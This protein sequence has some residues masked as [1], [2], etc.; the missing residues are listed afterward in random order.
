MQKPI[1]VALI[2]GGCVAPQLPSQASTSGGNQ[3]SQDAHTTRSDA[4]RQLRGEEI[5][6]LVLNK[7][8]VT[9]Q[10]TAKIRTFPREEYYLPD[11]QLRVREDRASS[12]IAY[13]LEG[14]CLCISAA[15]PIVKL[16]SRLFVDQRGNY[17]R[18]DIKPNSTG[19]VSIIISEM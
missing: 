4:L 13:W 6:K 7:R 2:L 15:S 1:F 16:C 19:P 8:I 12:R 17:Y 5:L 3:P 9:D 11:G 14:D 10:S 18:E